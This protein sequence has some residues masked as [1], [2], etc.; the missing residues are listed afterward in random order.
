MAISFKH[1]CNAGDLIASLP[2]I[3]QVCQT[4][5]QKAII[6]QA[7]NVKA[8]Y[9]DGAT[10][11]VT[12]EGDMVCMNEAMFNM[13]KPLLLSQSYI[14]D[15]VVF[16]GQKAI[17]DLD[18]IRDNIDHNQKHCFVNMPAG[19]IQSWIILAYPDMAT[20][21]SKPWLD[22]PLPWPSDGIATKGKIVLNYTERYRNPRI[23]YSF[24][25]EYQEHLLFAGTEKEN[26]IFS[27][28][29]KLEIP[30]LG[31]DDFLDLATCIKG[32]R[33]FA[34]NQ[35]MNWNI[36]NGIGVPRILEMCAFA[37][38]C[39]PFVGENNFGYYHQGAAEYYFDRLFNETK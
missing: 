37:P 30:H 11:P 17:V 3:K 5:G 39:Q 2:G 9:Y 6:Y 29:W 28:R 23:D 34:G 12:N 16:N 33:F 13:I 22:V 7:L 19:M 38:N 24:L 26:A 36:A 4:L 1:S 18:V 31:V 10:H 15:F 21:L 32:A 35:S 20:D 8:Y 14:E 27:S 25:K